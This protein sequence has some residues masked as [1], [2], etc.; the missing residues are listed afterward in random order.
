[1]RRF[2]LVILSE[3]RR[4]SRRTQSKDLLLVRGGTI[5]PLHTKSRS[6]DSGGEK[7]AACA[8]DDNFKEEAFYH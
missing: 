7:H 3:V 4:R 6:F 8:Q 5:L 2:Q 1:V